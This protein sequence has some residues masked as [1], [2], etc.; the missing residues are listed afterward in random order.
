MGIDITNFSA[1]F[2]W[3]IAHGYFFIFLVLCVEGP[4]VTAAAAFAAALGYFN[5]WVILLLSILGDLV[6]DTIYYVIG[7]FGRRNVIER[8]GSRLGLTHARMDR[9]A[10]LLRRNL[11]RT[12]VTLKL[13]PIVSTVGLALVGAL[14][15]SFG[16][17]LFICAAVTIPKSLIFFI[18]GFYFGH[19]YNVS[20]YIR[21]VE[22]WL[23]LVVL[24]G[25][26]FYVLHQKVVENI[27]KR[28]IAV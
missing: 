20:D 22:V 4:V 5:P 25:I 9:L 15:L 7:F 10:T 21:S 1:V 17:Y 27:R 19:L 18:I 12:M 24:S 6:P 3:V 11:R 8:F 28:N 16:R 2:Q 14:G 23:P 26:F 13:T